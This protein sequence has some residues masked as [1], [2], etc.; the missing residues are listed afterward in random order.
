VVSDA[1]WAGVASLL[2]PEERIE[3]CL[4]VGHYE[5]LAMALN[6]LG[7]EPEA[8]ALRKLDAH[9][10]RIADELRARLVRSRASAAAG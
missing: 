7:V 10:A 8:S 4:L 2:G 9:V 3:L 1:T 6:S 5:M